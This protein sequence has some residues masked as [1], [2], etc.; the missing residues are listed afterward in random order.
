MNPMKNRLSTYI[1]LAAAAVAWIFLRPTTSAGQT[2]AKSVPT[3]EQKAELRKKLTRTQYHITMENGTE[4]PFR[5]AYHD[6]K[7]AGVYLCVVSGKPLFSSKDKFDSGTGWPSFTRPIEKE[8]IEEVKDT[9]LGVT[10]IEVRSIPGNSHLGH[11]FDDGPKPTGLRYCI[12]SAALEFVPA[13]N[14]VE[15]GF[16][17]LAKAFGKE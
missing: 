17:E 7:A 5:N 6:N 15:R 3:A 9:S 4:P 8:V 13:A 12:N 1:L 14:L 10:R 2:D 11:V 16:P